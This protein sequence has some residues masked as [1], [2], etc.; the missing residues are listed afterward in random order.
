MRQ[1]LVYLAGP[2]TGLSFE[3]CVEWR[4]WFIDQLPKE[5]VGLSPMRGKDYLE[6]EQDLKMDYAHIVLSSGRGITARDYNDCRRA[7]LIVANMLGAKKV[8]IGTVMEIAWAKAF[9]VPV[10]LV[11]EPKGNPHDHAMLTECVGF[12][13]PTLEEA[14][15][16][17]KVILLPAPHRKPYTPQGSLTR[18]KFEGILKD[19]VENP[20]KYLGLE[21]SQKDKS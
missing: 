9:N 8:S 6:H 10:V 19:L 20:D 4:E 7:D 1:H 17:T 12:R 2:I 3:G 5:I 18:E 11:M 13:T 21:K 16:L 14:L 15:W